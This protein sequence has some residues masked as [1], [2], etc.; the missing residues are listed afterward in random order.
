MDPAALFGSFGFGASSL[1]RMDKRKL[2]AEIKDEMKTL[3]TSISDY[4]VEQAV[5]IVKTQL[6]KLEV[7]NELDKKRI[8]E[9]FE[10]EI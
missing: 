3:I 2:L 1:D 6:R 10:K 7:E 9:R 5:S 8:E 4:Q